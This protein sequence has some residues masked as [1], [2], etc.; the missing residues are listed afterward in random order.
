MAVRSWLLRLSN[1]DS[2]IEEEGFPSSFS[3][4]PNF[5]EIDFFLDIFLLSAIIALRKSKYVFGGPDESG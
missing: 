3:V 4:L 5:P 2:G 1:L